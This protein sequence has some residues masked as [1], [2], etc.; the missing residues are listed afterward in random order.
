[1]AGSDYQLRLRATLDTTQVQQELKK[2]RAA[3]TMSFDQGGSGTSKGLQGV[4]NMQK[5]E[6]QLTKLNSSIAGLQQAIE[7]LS[8]TQSNTAHQSN[9]LQGKLKSPQ[10]PYGLTKKEFGNWLDS[11]E[12]KSLNRKV[13]N[14]LK[15]NA[16]RYNGRFANYEGKAY[17]LTDPY[18]ANRVMGN[19][20]LKGLDKSL[21]KTNYQ[22]QITNWN[23]MN[24]HQAQNQ[25]FTQGRQF[26]GVIGGQLLGGA[27]DIASA[28]GYTNLGNFINSVG[29]G[30]T[31]GASAAMGMSLAGF[32]A[33][34]SSVVGIAVGLGTAIAENI[35]NMEQL[36][37]AVSKTAQAFE[38]NYKWL[39]HQTIGIQDSIIGSRHRTRANQLLESGN[40]DEAKKQA[41]YWTNAYESA[42]S[43]FD[44][45]RDPWQVERDIREKA[46]QEKAMVEKY[47][48]TSFA[49]D[50]FGKDNT[51]VGFLNKAL[52]F[53]TYGMRKQDILNQIDDDA[54]RQIRDMQQRYKDLESEMNKYKGYADTYQSV[55]DKL[56]NDK[57]AEAQKSN[58]EVQKRLSL[59]ERNDQ[60][61][62]RYEA[63]SRA[64]KTKALA[65]DILGNN[66]LSPLE[67]FTKISDE[68]DKLRATRKTALEGAYGI[69]KDIAN[70]KMTSEE[71]TRAMAKQSKY[72]FQ[73]SSAANLIGI[74]ENALTNISTQTIAPDLSHMTSLSQYGFNMGEKDDRVERMEKYYNKSLTLQQQIKDKLQEGI[75][76][77]AVYN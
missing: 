23:R 22:D 7:R 64:N 61:M 67:K 55:A 50:W 32:G 75:K 6:V 40:I 2:L 39:H 73:A 17:D 10:L 9:V 74:L 24:Q 38:E 41:D 51:T 53:Q 52:G 46:E 58:A 33:K 48:P 62:A 15:S 1:M 16:D 57:N 70:G 30:V 18:L 19:G 69:S 36:A 13:A 68:L 25:Q 45:T 54:Q 71:M 76:T 27:G 4:S 49:E 42:K 65:N 28:M 77:E 5:I 31:G 12:Y 72:E 63:Q 20:V 43:S 21:N 59:S 3:Q 29:S 35:S 60:A 44:N 56:E 47:I 26:A 14:L 66:N 34:A 11:N 37:Q 8:R